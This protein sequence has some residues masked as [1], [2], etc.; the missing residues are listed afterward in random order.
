VHRSKRS[1]FRKR[2]HKLKIQLFI[3]T[4][5]LTKQL[6]LVTKG[7]LKL[8]DSQRKTTGGWI[9]TYIRV[10]VRDVSRKL[11]HEANAGELTWLVLDLL[12]CH[13]RF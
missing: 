2:I 1:N 7:I 13:T 4:K 5:N 12:I 10:R 8:N 11:A 9:I 6:V 3:L